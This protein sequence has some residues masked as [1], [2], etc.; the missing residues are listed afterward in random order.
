MGEASA[1]V[2]FTGN[3]G[4][5]GDGTGSAVILDKAQDFMPYAERAIVR[6]Q[7]Q[8]K[9]E[10]EKKARTEADR[11]KGW[12][13]LAK[14][15]DAGDIWRPAV[16]KQN[17]M[18]NQV[19]EEMTDLVQQGLNPEDVYSLAGKRFLELKKQVEV[20]TK[21]Q[22]TA[23]GLVKDYYAKMNDPKLKGTFD[24]DFAQDWFNKLESLPVEKKAEFA[25]T[26]SPIV[27]KVNYDE[28]VG[29][30]TPKPTTITDQSGK[31]RTTTVMPK[32]EDIELL[33]D[34]GLKGNPKVQQVYE[35]GLAKG[36][37]EDEAGFK[38]FYKQKIK[39]KEGSKTQEVIIGGGSSGGGSGSGAGVSPKVDFSIETDPT[40]GLIQDGKPNRFRVKRLGTQDDLPPVSIRPNGK[41]V[42]GKGEE[43]KIDGLIDFQPINWVVGAD[44]RM[45]IEGNMVTYKSDSAGNDVQQKETV[46]VDY[47]S[48]KSIFNAQ[49]GTDPYT[50]LGR[51]KPSGQT[52]SKP[53]N[54]KP[55][56]Y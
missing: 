40:Q 32:D 4:G 8:N 53:T 37:W 2:V 24:E 5:I 22:Q 36:D 33:I 38:E 11:K 28:I 15:L 35:A 9:V 25:I 29:V 51:N 34:S 6:Q 46:W 3:Q 50:V 21:E 49:I 20:F 26:S 10:A 48:N 13:D 43:V 12:Y 31:T 1:S 44:G 56:P 30:L 23:E 54:K 18:M 42:N 52:Q 47:E 55:R 19:F 39:A 17:E 27:P 41:V 45:G 16:E 14:K 7:A